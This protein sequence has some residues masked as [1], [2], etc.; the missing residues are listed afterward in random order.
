MKI[1]TVCL[2]DSYVTG[3]EQLVEKNMYPSR[4]EVIRIAIRDLLMSELW[5]THD[6]PKRGPLIRTPNSIPDATIS[7][8]HE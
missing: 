3:M 8:V 6:R 4:S 7:S 5:N 2:P 1:V